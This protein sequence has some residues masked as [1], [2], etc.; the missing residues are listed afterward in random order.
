[1]RPG[2]S[3]AEP[4]LLLP[5]R[6]RDRLVGSGALDAGRW[7]AAYEERVRSWDPRVRAFAEFR[8]P[9]TA[10]PRIPEH[11]TVTY[12]DTIDVRG[13]ASR[14]GI[15][16]GY[17][18]Y[19]QRSAAP[20]ERIAE[21]GYVCVGKAATTEV[22]IGTLIPTRNP[23][24]PAVSA[25]G[26]SCGSGAAVACGF[27]DLSVCTDSGG[28]A[29]W[30]AVYCGAA[31]LRLSHDRDLLRGVLPV[32]PSMESIALVTRTVDDLDHL[33]RERGLRDAVGPPPGSRPPSGG[34]S[35]GMV[36]D[37]FDE[38]VDP[39]VRA[40]LE[41]LCGRL[42]AAG[43]PVRDA[44][45]SWWDTRRAAWSLLLREAWDV[46]RER[47]RDA[48]HRGTRTALGIGRAVSDAEYARLLAERDQAWQAAERQLS[49]DP[50]VLLLP[51]DP[52]LA[53]RVPDARRDSTVPDGSPGFTMTASFAGLPA[54]ALP[55]G[56]ATDG[57]PIGVQLIA[58]RGAEDLLIEA[59]RLVESLCAEQ[60]TDIGETP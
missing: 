36:S 25:G 21:H 55:M 4:G 48:Y 42:A 54:L 39:Q 23:R 26:S 34:W 40:A 50:Q 5:L 53:D 49:A 11:P 32:S 8:P 3:V 2:A 13:H 51:L 18:H 7:R 17:R 37:C 15:A 16:T 47:G 22:S 43:R 14:L 35:F 46:H 9:D 38:P 10:D 24:W 12:K 29:R 33:W 31:A 59:G 41:A 1:M 45:V 44:A 57:S 6:R 56:Y 60:T 19:P 28:S 52:H 20:V 30:P 58:R 27:C